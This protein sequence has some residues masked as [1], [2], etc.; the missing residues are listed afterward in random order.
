MGSLR[1]LISLKKKKKWAH[2]KIEDKVNILK[3]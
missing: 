1:E 2:Q 3:Q